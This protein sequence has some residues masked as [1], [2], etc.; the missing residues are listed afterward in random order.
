MR[1]A[2]FG[3][4]FDPPHLGH[5]LAALYARLIGGA[6]AVWVLPSAEHPYGKPLTP[7]ADRLML[8]QLAFADLSFAEVRDDER[9]NP[10]GYTIGLVERLRATHPER[11]WLL[12]GGTDTAHDLP[13][14][15][16]G[17]E[18]T[19]LVEVLAVPRRGYDDDPA[20]LPAISSSLVRERLRAGD[21]CRDLLPA[22]VADRIAAN[23][24]YR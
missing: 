8:C 6:E 20:A 13:N 17:A 23:G 5:V 7:F 11:T 24:W 15:R 12:I 9:G 16:R 18:L 22:A 19:R 21:P 14:W 10:G 1:T 3:G 4:S 2:L